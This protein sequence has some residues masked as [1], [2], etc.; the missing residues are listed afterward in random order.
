[1]V[2]LDSYE[3]FYT[4]YTHTHTHLIFYDAIIKLMCG[5]IGIHE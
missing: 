1:L 3:L 2:D 4:V 5:G